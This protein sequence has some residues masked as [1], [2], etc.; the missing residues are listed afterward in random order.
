MRPLRSL[1][2]STT[3]LLLDEHPA[4]NPAP[5]GSETPH[6]PPPGYERRGGGTGPRGDLLTGSVREYG[7]DPLGAMR[8]WR[9]TFGDLVPLRFGPI[10]A[11]MA[12]GPI[13]V[14]EVLVAHAKDYRK[15]IGIRALM[16]VLGKGLLTDEGDSWLRSRRL[17][18]PAFHRERIALYAGNSASLH[19]P[20]WA[21]WL[22]CSAGTKMFGCAAKASSAALRFGAR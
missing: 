18:A 7:A 2:I 6:R 21:S 17:I 4:Q 10:R 14:T 5:Q 3:L 22:P 8:R 13:E 9:D 11:L 15:S 20:I 12:F 19:A 16:P 1:L